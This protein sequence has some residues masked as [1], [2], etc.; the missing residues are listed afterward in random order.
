MTTTDRRRRNGRKAAALLWLLL[1]FLSIGGCADPAQGQSGPGDTQA[2][3]EDA[4]KTLGKPVVTVLMDLPVEADYIPDEFSK[5]MSGLPGYGEDF[6]VRFESLPK[7]GADREPALTRVRTEIL[8]GKGPDLF[9][10]AQRLYGVTA[11]PDDTPFFPF[12]VQAMTNHLFLPLDD[13]IE[14]AEYMDM[15]TMQPTVMAAGCGE[16][17]QQIIPLTYTFEATF[18]DKK[19]Y[20]PKRDFP[21]TWEDMLD[22]PDSE[23]RYAASYGGARLQDIIGELADYSKDV[24]AFSEEELLSWAGMMFNTYKA[25]PEEMK[26]EESLLTLPLTPLNISNA[27]IDLSGDQ[28]YT[29]IPAYNRDGGITANITTFAAINRNARRPVEAFKIIDYLMKPQVQL[30]SPL[31]Q[32]R[33]EG[34]P[35]YMFTSDDKTLRSSS[36]RMSEANFMTFSSLREQIDTA[37]FPGPLDVC[38]WGVQAYD[39]DVLEKSVHE[40]YVLMQM[41][42][43]ES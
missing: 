19:E 41:Y 40:Q 6:M 21:M 13:Y 15:D 27:A 16:E 23:I 38:L 42:L 26:E 33:M 3:A 20:A 18:F 2:A 1:T 35:V 37:K 29:I 30:T 5:S 32:N 31:Y 36:W 11:G 25:L 10:C 9:L 14:K 7:S 12:P 34:I 8:A 22:D 24:P 43:A 4:E 17:G 39:K 28:E